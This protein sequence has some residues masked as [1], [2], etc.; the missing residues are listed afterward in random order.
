MRL[1]T[2][3]ILDDNIPLMYEILHFVFCGFLSIM[4]TVALFK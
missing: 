3:G 2:L 1:T 4:V